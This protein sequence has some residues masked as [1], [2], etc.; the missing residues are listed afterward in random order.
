MPYLALKLEILIVL[1]RRA[2]REEEPHSANTYRTSQTRNDWSYIELR[3]HEIDSEFP[4]HG[5]WYVM[6][7]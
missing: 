6:I 7:D 3:F 4:W 2:Q 1:W 5:I